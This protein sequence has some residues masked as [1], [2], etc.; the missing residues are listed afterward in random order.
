[1]VGD[2]DW[3]ITELHINL[4]LDKLLTHKVSIRRQGHF[5]DQWLHICILILVRAIFHLEVRPGKQTWE[6]RQE[7]LI[8][9]IFKTLTQRSDFLRENLGFLGFTVNSTEHPGE[10]VIE[11]DDSLIIPTGQQLDPAETTNV[12]VELLRLPPGELHQFL[13]IDPGL[14]RPELVEVSPEDDDLGVVNTLESHQL[15]TKTANA[16]HVGELRDSL[17]PG[18]KLVQ[19]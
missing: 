9:S 12:H 15:I 1:M 4:A 16:V 3:N 7:M 18:K 13:H 14:V 2:S 6:Q 11:P 19:T 8:S 10:Q 17:Q 5:V